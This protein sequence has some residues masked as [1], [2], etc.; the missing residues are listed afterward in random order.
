[1][2]L[3]TAEPVLAFLRSSPLE[4][5]LCVFNL[6]PNSESV[7]L[8]LPDG[9]GPLSGTRIRPLNGH[10]LMGQFDGDRLDL[11]A[12]GAVFALVE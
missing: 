3:D 6:G 12:Y 7:W 1:V 8:S 2:F 5:L 10:G 4:R 11:P 9:A